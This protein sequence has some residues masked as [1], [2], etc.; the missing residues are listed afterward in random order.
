VATLFED[1]TTTGSFGQPLRFRQP[2]TRG[3]QDAASGFGAVEPVVGAVQRGLQSTPS[4]RAALAA[5]T[6]LPPATLSG[7]TEPPLGGSA[8]GS[9]FRRAYFRNAGLAAP[10]EEPAEEKGY[11]G[12][13]LAGA[14]ERAADLAGSFLEALDSLGWWLQEQL[15]GPVFDMETGEAVAADTPEQIAELRATR[16]GWLANVGKWASSADFGYEPRYTWETV[17]EGEGVLDTLKR[18][19]L[20]GFETLVTSTPDMVSAVFNPVGYGVA[21]TGDIA[22]QR[23]ENDG[24]G[25][26]E[27]RDLLN[28]ASAA[29]L[30]ATLER[31]S[32]VFTLAGGGAKTI[33]GAIGRAAGVEAGTEALQSAGE[34]TAATAGT[35]RGF[36]SEELLDTMAGGAVA[37]L[38]GGGTLGGVSHALTRNGV[39]PAVDDAINADTEVDMGQRLLPPP[40]EAQAA[41]DGTI[42]PPAPNEPWARRQRADVEEELA[43]L[44]EQI[45]AEPDPA[46]RADLVNKFRASV[47]ELQTAP[48][49]PEGPSLEEAGAALR[50]PL[51]DTPPV[52]EP[53]A[54]E[55]MLAA[56]QGLTPPV[57]PPGR[58][59]RG[60]PTERGAEQMLEAGRAVQPP[61][62]PPEGGVSPAATTEETD[63]SGEPISP[64]SEALFQRAMERLDA[65]LARRQAIADGNPDI[66]PA[67]PLADEWAFL[68]TDYATLDPGD[69]AGL[70]E[71]IGRALDLQE[72]AETETG[73]PVDNTELGAEEPAGAP[74]GPPVPPETTASFIT[75]EETP[76]QG[77]RKK[78]APVTTTDDIDQM[79]E[80]PTGVSTAEAAT[81]NIVA[82]AEQEVVEE[83]SRA[84]GTGELVQE[85]GTTEAVLDEVSGRKR[86]RVS[87]KEKAEIQQANQEL[88]EKGL[89]VPTASAVPKP[90]GSDRPLTKKEQ[91]ELGVGAPAQTLPGR[92]AALAVPKGGKAK[93]VSRRR[94]RKDRFSGVVDDF[95]GPP[96]HEVVKDSPLS[97]VHALLDSVYRLAQA[98]Q[99]TGADA[100]RAIFK[101]RGRVNWSEQNVNEARKRQN[102]RLRQLGR[103][104]EKLE[105]ART[106]LNDRP[107]REEFLVSLREAM[108]YIQTLTSPEDRRL[109]ERA[110]NTS[111]EALGKV[112]ERL[113]TRL[114]KDVAAAQPII[115]E[116]LRVEAT[117][118][119]PG[120]EPSPRGRQA[121][122]DGTAKIAEMS[123]GVRTTKHRKAPRPR[124]DIQRALELFQLSRA[125]D[126]KAEPK[127]AAAIGAKVVEPG[128]V[129]VSKK[130]TAR[131]K[132]HYRSLIDTRDAEARDAAYAKLQELREAIA[133]KV[134]ARLARQEG[135]NVQEAEGQVLTYLAGLE[136]EIMGRRTGPTF[137]KAVLATTTLPKRTRAKKAPA[138][139]PTPERKLTKGERL[140]YDNMF[141]NLLRAPQDSRAL[142]RWLEERKRLLAAGVP[143]KTLLAAEVQAS[144]REDARINREVEAAPDAPVRKAEVTERF[145]AETRQRALDRYRADYAAGV[146]VA[147]SG[148]A[149]RAAG[150]TAAELKAARE[151]VAQERARA[152]A[153]AAAQRQAPSSPGR[154][155]SGG[156]AEMVRDLFGGD[157]NSATNFETALAW[158]KTRRLAKGARDFLA[159]IERLDMPSLVSRLSIRFVDTPERLLAISKN[160]RAVAHYRVWADG[161]A[162]IFIG[163]QAPVRALLHE[164]AH[165]T[166]AVNLRI[167]PRLHGRLNT[168]LE[169]TRN[170]LASHPEVRQEWL[171][172]KDI[173]EFAAEAFTDPAF[174]D[175]LR[176]IPMKEDSRAST[177]WRYWLS[178]V[179]KFFSTPTSVMDQIVSLRDEVVTRSE[180]SRAPPIRRTFSDPQPSSRRTSGNKR[181][182]RFPTLASEEATARRGNRTDFTQPDD[183]SPLPLDAIFSEGSFELVEA[184]RQSVGAPARRSF[185][186]RAL[187]VA[188]GFMT[189]QNI[190]TSYADHFNDTAQV[191]MA[192]KKVRYSGNPLRTLNTVLEQKLGF[193]R[194]LQNKA[195]DVVGAWKQLARKNRAGVV[196]LHR[197]MQYA[198]LRRL[199]PNLPASHPD[200]KGVNPEAHARAA[201]MWAALPNE[202]KE[203]YH[204]VRKAYE[205]SFNARISIARDQ[206]LRT[207]GYNLPGDPDYK[208]GDPGSIDPAKSVTNAED[209]KKLIDAG[210][211]DNEMGRLLRQVLNVRKMRRGPYFRQMRVGNWVVYA[212]RDEPRTFGS[213]Q[214]LQAFIADN[215]DAQV[216]S[217]EPSI[218]KAKPGQPIKAVISF[219]SFAAFENQAEAR[220][221]REEVLKTGHYK[222]GEVSDVVPRVSREYDAQFLPQGMVD[223]IVKKIVGEG[224]LKVTDPVTGKESS[225]STA[226]MAQ[227]VRTAFLELLPDTGARLTEL[228]RRNIWGGEPD[229]LKAFAAHATA[230]AYLQAEMTYGRRQAAAMS[231]LINV[232][233]NPAFTSGPDGATRAAVV[234][235][236]VKRDAGG[237]HAHED[238]RL[239][240]RITEVGFV[241][242]LVSA[243]YSIT[244]MTQ[245][246]LLTLPYLSARYGKGATFLAFKRA[247]AAFTPTLAGRSVKSWFGMKRFTRGSPANILNIL[248]DMRSRITQAGFSPDTVRMFDTLVERGHID[249]T[250]VLDTQMAAEQGIGTDSALGR[251]SRGWGAIVEAG[252]VMPH[253]VEAFN[254][255]VT[256]VMAFQLEMSRS[257]DYNKALAAADDA[258]V[259][260]QGDY[261]AENRARFMSS[262]AP[263]LGQAS[264]IIF[265][266]KQYPQLIY[267][268]FIRHFY[269][270]VHRVDP[271]LPAAKQQ[272]LRERRKVAR[273]TLTGMF[274]SHALAAGALGAMWEPIK[275]AVGLAGMAFGGDDW[276]GTEVEFRNL[277]ADAFGAEAGE[278]IS[279]GLP[280]AIGLDMSG[281]LGIDEL[282]WRQLPYGLSSKEEVHAGVFQILGPMFALGAN[283]YDGAN[284]ILDAETHAE[285]MAGL[286]Q[287]LPKALR[288]TVRSLHTWPSEGV[289]SRNGDLLI[290]PEELSPGDLFI[291]WSGITPSQVAETYER[292]SA[293]EGARDIADSR[294]SELL[295]RF[296][297]A[298]DEGGDR[299][300]VLAE[301]Q[302]YNRAY[303]SKAITRS[304]LAKSVSN[305]RDRQRTLEA[306]GGVY[307]DRRDRFLLESGRFATVE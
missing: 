257:K 263:F 137:A 207:V 79:Q 116:A 106:E 204:K 191:P 268:N 230:D 220:A 101:A 242:Y 295:D 13:V 110:L 227:A 86:R 140:K 73:G 250:A 53:G 163:P 78:P 120:A 4:G 178:A 176:S 9:T 193:I 169:I 56:G 144:N 177:G 271:S 294:R 37:G 216:K 262:N 212:K 208:A 44:R 187:Q 195:E 288:D 1:D 259:N 253:Y 68:A 14:G 38:V 89:L 300:A 117:T 41:G 182:W 145:R 136:R 238:N 296:W 87:K 151:A 30:T 184:L 305:R 3:V 247:T 270:A 165:V 232:S 188:L 303:P 298:F 148:K 189:R 210:R 128:D 95:T 71:I 67:G 129:G 282:L 60:V 15:G 235:E 221:F 258:V 218:S 225:T 50:P 273:R 214:E 112:S 226:R 304:V 162:E 16:G 283:Y 297:V 301:I 139:E 48:E 130:D 164:L 115:D 138:P 194:G 121:A 51:P 180:G 29:A 272:A 274:L 172:T 237:L 82:A 205:D 126:K 248:D 20:F 97:Q 244:N 152:A 286:E 154:E 134:G 59:P 292:R 98:A 2:Y 96:T 81:A 251:V 24:R 80:D 211:L 8:G 123:G 99:A 141:V 107:A 299:S 233:H 133:A 47:R 171:G 92:D 61:L 185:K 39:D 201:R 25:Y 132:S 135:I 90:K 231:D 102:R 100:I 264:R 287:M 266:F 213:V 22:K 54:D 49:A 5:S 285:F 222:Q 160:P 58:P 21:L 170:Y 122:R 279:R 179:S 307:V 77:R 197:L 146:S 147:A 269:D 217:A 76:K 131:Y 260:T 281:R 55:A 175:L 173:D 306:T 234:A 83:A 156:A 219:T 11:L 241:S 302:A 209:V 277:M 167:D 236:M 239:I 276:E 114:Q 33:R 10:T 18:T 245:V 103:L 84:A 228:R 46:K 108:G 19:L 181:N 143:E 240:Q 206:I 158:L 252:R 174:Q 72:A 12:N 161:R 192:D 202:L 246:P 94:S 31:F 159:A 109:L 45:A 224:P 105:T 291:Q 93:A 88:E 85:A 118:A 243:S 198:T 63:D 229:A 57:V 125:R 261:T 17:K 119:E 69:Q 7:D 40:R 265:M 290:R 74:A 64:E 36:D 43:T 27:M 23:A 52:A 186:N 142:N 149:A 284:R 249:M 190:V 6:A 278:L 62:V 75:Q 215:I 150:V 34:Y 111:L 280:R 289:V 168:A 196:Q 155:L 32:T 275:W 35:Q 153:V 124:R 28:A 91:A 70:D 157:R 255:T 26:V 113:A 183:E 256:A 65:E 254:R 293:I 42:V 127:L 223:R 166:V 200:N 203:H 199:H 104:L 66:G 267:Y